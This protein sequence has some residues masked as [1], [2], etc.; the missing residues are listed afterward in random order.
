MLTSQ[1]RDDVIQALAQHLVM[2]PMGAL[3]TATFSLA[4]ARELGDLPTNLNNVRAQAI[5]LVDVCIS[6]RWRLTPSLLES[7]LNRLVSSG[8]GPL[9][10]LLAR[11]QQKIDPNPD[12]F[13][14]H[15]VLASHPFLSR[16]DLRKAA[17]A[18]VESVNQPILRVNGPTQSGKTY[19][20]EL[21]GY[22]MMDQGW[23]NLHV[24]RADMSPGTGPSYT[25]EDLASN[26][27]LSMVTDKL[28]ER[29][30]SSFPKELARWLMRN[31]NQNKGL[32]IFVLDGFGQ[33]SVQPE[34][35]ELIYEL[36]QYAMN[37]EFSKKM[38]LV[39]LDYQHDL[40]G[41]WRAWTADEGP[42]SVNGVTTGDLVDCLQ[43][44]NMWM[45]AEAPAKMIQPSD[46]PVI[47]D[48]ML[49]RSQAEPPQL[50]SLYQQLL[51]IAR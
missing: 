51:K 6:S 9:A 48:A 17:R 8:N 10:P 16:P 47:A 23:P 12:P 41:N 46:I 24:A 13:R 18:L 15:W 3:L 1:E 37:P 30:T 14:T 20:K 36:V 42:L 49:T 44:F 34:V 50:P 19:T 22:V 26:L 29:S 32:W 43:S 7:L 35:I 38:R 39:L 25:V 31:L 21:F 28:P 27:A 45:P 5:W 33:P 4:A 2:T 11:V 40:I